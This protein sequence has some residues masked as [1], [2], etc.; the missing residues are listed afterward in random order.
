M[1]SE[2]RD[3]LP[4]QGLPM[5]LLSELKEQIPCDVIGSV[6]LADR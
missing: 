2:Q 4:D 5:S 6:A 3:D 1:V